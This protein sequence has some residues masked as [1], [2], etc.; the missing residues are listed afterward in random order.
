M[1]VAFAPVALGAQTLTQTDADTKEVLS[2]RL[3]MDAYR[4]V[5]VAYQALAEEQKKDPNYQALSRVKTEREALQKKEEPTDADLQRIEELQTKEREIQDTID[6]AEI[7]MKDNAT[8]AEFAAELEREPRIAAALRKGG[9]SA[10]EFA[11]F[12]FAMVAAGFAAGL[13]K[14]GML[15]ELPKEVN[16]ENVKFILEHE[17]ELEKLM[18]DLKGSDKDK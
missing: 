10:R 5:A 9:I 8:L 4:K 7:K 1:V 17:A 14:A 18:G 15:K 16:A 2:Y 12:T 6:K 3:T 13:Q 11:T